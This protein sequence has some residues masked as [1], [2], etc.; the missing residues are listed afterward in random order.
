[1]LP[2]ASE[3]VRQDQA[4]SQLS[5]LLNRWHAVAIAKVDVHGQ[6]MLPLLPPLPAPVPEDGSQYEV[7]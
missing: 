1:L 7:P 3:L 6:P 2:V 4:C 5:R